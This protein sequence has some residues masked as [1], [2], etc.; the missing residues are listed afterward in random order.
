MTT[1]RCP[2]GSQKAY[3]E[4][5][6]RV[7]QNHAAADHPEKL[8][9]SRYSAHVKGLVDFIVDTYHPSCGAEQHRDAIVQSINSEWLM[10]QVLSSSVDE[11]GKQGFVEF[12]AHYKEAGKQYCLHEKSR[13][14]T[15]EKDGHALWYYIDGE[16]PKAEKVGRN[17][18]CP[19]GSGKK[20]K[21]CC[22]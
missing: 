13:F 19:C 20:Y 11:S 15:E 21:K 4:C 18:P 9:R 14:V 16:Y 17:D 12:K 1:S 8:M 22:G 3:S 7:H 2:C 5:C 10:L 6:E